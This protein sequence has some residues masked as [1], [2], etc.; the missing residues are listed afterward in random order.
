MVRDWL[1]EIKY[2]KGGKP[3]FCIRRLRAVFIGKCPKC[4]APLNWDGSC[5]YASNS[6]D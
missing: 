2:G 4:N 6:F 5:P 1:L 3:G